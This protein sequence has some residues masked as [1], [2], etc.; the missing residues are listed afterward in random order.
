MVNSVVLTPII[1]DKDAV[2]WVSVVA[3]IGAW[4]AALGVV[5]AVMAFSFGIINP[6][7]FKIAQTWLIVADV[8]AILMLGA[9]VPLVNETVLL[10]FALIG[11]VLLLGITGFVFYIIRQ[12]NKGDAGVVGIVEGTRR[13]IEF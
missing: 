2:H 8:G 13:R 5:F 3:V 12:Y 10:V 7:L 1:T 6:R 9:V 4:F 11:I